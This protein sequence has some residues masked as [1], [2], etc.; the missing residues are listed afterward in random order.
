MSHFWITIV[1]ATGGY[2]VAAFSIFLGYKLLLAGA[3]GQFSFEAGVFGGTFRP[4]SVAPGIGF[5]SFGMVIAIDT[6]WHLVSG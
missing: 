3:T 5:A 2:S 6:T 1:C 4:K